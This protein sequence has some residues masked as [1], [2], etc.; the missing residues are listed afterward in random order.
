[1]T[2]TTL[3]TLLGVQL[4]SKAQMAELVSSDDSMQ[5]NIMV[6]TLFSSKLLALVKTGFS[7]SS[8][9]ANKKKIAK[10]LAIILSHLSDLCNECNYDFPEDEELE[11][12]YS[13]MPL[14]VKMDSLVV[15]LNLIGYIVELINVIYVDYADNPPIW[16]EEEPP[17]AL[18]NTVCEILVA[19][20]VLCERQAISMQDVFAEMN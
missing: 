16:G 8:T 3:K 17:E 1:M 12:F 13:S 2:K 4:A 14:E 5:A 20:R 6:M 9:E 18:Q 15:A 11:G 7:G 10:C 19:M